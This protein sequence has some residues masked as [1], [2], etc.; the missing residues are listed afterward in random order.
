VAWL[1][2]R[3]RFSVVTHRFAGALVGPASGSQPVP[4]RC[5]MTTAIPSAVIVPVAPAFTNAERLALAGFLAGYSGLTRQAYELDLRQFASWCQQ[6]QLCLFQARRADIEFFARDLEA[7]GR[8]RATSAAACALWPGSIATRSRKNCS[9]IP[10]PRTSAGPGWTTNPT[11]PAWTATNS[12]RSW[13]NRT[14]RA[15]R[16]C[17]DLAAGPQ[18]TARLRSHRC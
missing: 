10:R 8:A 12:A 17:A 11:L 7:R 9:I 5:P 15:R 6:H 4:R 3:G 2:T 18:R 1:V 13:R 16:A 14:R